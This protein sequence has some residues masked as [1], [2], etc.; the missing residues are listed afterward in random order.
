MRSESEPDLTDEPK[1]DGLGGFGE[2]ATIQPG[3]A[4][5]QAEA[6]TDVPS[7]PADPADAPAPN[8]PLNPA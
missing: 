4:D 3:V 2:A 8:G 7:A 6:G 5:E 1:S